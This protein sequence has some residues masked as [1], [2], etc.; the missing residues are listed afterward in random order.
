M[1]IGIESLNLLE[2]YFQHSTWLGLINNFGVTVF[3]SL[4]YNAA[5]FFLYSCVL[6]VLYQKRIN[7]LR[8]IFTSLLYCMVAHGP[9]FIINILRPLATISFQIEELFVAP[10]P[11]IILFVYLLCAYFLRID[12]TIS[13]STANKLYVVIVGNVILYYMLEAMFFFLFTNNVY[14]Q[15]VIYFAANSLLFLINII[16]AGFFIRFIKVQRL[17]LDAYKIKKSSD[18]NVT[19]S[20]VVSMLL[21]TLLWLLVV[22]TL[23]LISFSSGIVTVEIVMSGLLL[24]CFLIFYI[25]YTK[26][27]KK[28]AKADVDNQ[29]VHV[30]SL[31]GSIDN[32]RALKHDMHNMLAVYDGYIKLKEWD[33]LSQYHASLHSETRFA[34]ELL[35]INTKYTI[36]P[37][38]RNLLSTKLS[39]AHDKKVFINI[40]ILSDT[41][42][43]GM[44]PLD[45]ARIIGILLDNA[46]EETIHTDTKTILLS[47][48]SMKNGNI[49]LSLSNPTVDDVDIK[50][51]AE[52]NYTTKEGHSGLGLFTL[53]NIVSKA[54]GCKLSI[55]YLDKIVTFY[56]ELACTPS[57]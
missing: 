25:S 52:K 42:N 10:P 37:I 14:Y 48:Q 24:N 29:T 32:I 28:V 34:E 1:F 45:L 50:K 55:D 43:I 20:L 16:A 26:D 2:N 3:Q 27:I 8:Y 39:E 21:F 51:I 33:K 53:W 36:N 13:I 41:D 6:S 35:N 57:D 19:R 44:D 17:W 15:M 56:L 46:M 23:K 22:P 7:I 9:V 47:L 5:A 12:K 54:T 18:Y 49:L 38:L 11:Y 40:S 31:I 30:N 4:F